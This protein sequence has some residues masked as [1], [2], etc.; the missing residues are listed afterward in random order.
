MTLVDDYKRQLA[1]R[2]WGTV[3]DAIPSLQDHSVLDLGCGVGDVAALLTDRGARVTGVDL[4]E[5]LLEAARNRE[6][7]RA[8]FRCCDLR[9]LPAPEELAGK[10]DG[11]WCG[12]TLAY[13]TDPI[14]VV[15]GWARHLRPGGWIAVIE[16]DDLFGHE[17]L[18]DST[19]A[20]LNAYA[21]DALAAGRYE[22]RMGSK[23]RRVLEH[24]GF[25][26]THEGELADRELAFDGPASEDVL[27]G[28]RQRL[29]RMKLLHDFCGSEFD[30]VREDL[31]GCL[32]SASH[33]SLARVRWCIG[34]CPS[35]AA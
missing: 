33:R 26:V 2:S 16:I 4:S 19:S 13:F 6:L 12:F 31:L 29:D 21:E 18:R 8:S 35:P 28:W 25:K 20:L 34:I 32:G 23:L 11:I 14:P 3:V 17:P 27:Q 10:V 22:F 30:A 7:P 9:A 5:E 1:W 15:N 24:C